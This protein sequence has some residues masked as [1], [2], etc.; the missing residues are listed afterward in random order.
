MYVGD[1]GKLHFV[2]S[3]GADTALPFSGY[4]MYEATYNG[5]IESATYELDL[6]NII[7]NYTELTADNFMGFAIKSFTTIG[8]TTTVINPRI[9]N[10]EPSTGTIKFVCSNFR[11][12]TF[13]IVT[14]K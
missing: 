13:L 5:W 1:D 2:D 9:T 3:A 11:N 4:K 6:S 14:N 10:Y 8:E 7:S 12:V